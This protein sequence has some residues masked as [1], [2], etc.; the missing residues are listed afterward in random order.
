MPPRHKRLD[1]HRLASLGIFDE[2]M[3]ETIASGRPLPNRATLGFLLLCE[4][5]LQP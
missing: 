3:P 2:A 1:I 5:W 4:T